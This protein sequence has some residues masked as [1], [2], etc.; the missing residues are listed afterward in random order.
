LIYINDIDNRIASK[1]LKFADDTKL[2]RRVGTAEDIVKLRND[3]EKLAGWSKE[4]LMLFNVEKCK[5]MHTGFGIGRA[6]YMMDSMECNYKRCMKKWMLGYWC[7][8]I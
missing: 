7:R 3:Q 2:Y 8:I 6:R 4:W 1:N 5:V